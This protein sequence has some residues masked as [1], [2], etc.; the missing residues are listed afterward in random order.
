MMVLFTGCIGQKTPAVP[1][2]QPPAV[3]VDYQQTGGIAGQDAHLV[4]FDNGA[5]VISTR[6][7]STEIELNKTDLE[8]ITALFI[9][10]QFSMLQTNYPAPHAGA[11]MVNYSISYHGKTVT[12]QDTAIPPAIQPVLN[13]LNRI[14]TSV[15]I[16][17]ANRPFVSVKL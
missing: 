2:P 15:E 14:V 6:S 8:H 7:A 12:L 5:S 9:D 13:E 1:E 16:Q 11:D 3:F 17:K 4:I 10:A